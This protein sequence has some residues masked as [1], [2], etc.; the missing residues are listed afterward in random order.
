MIL[1]IEKHPSKILST[2]TE[3][4][5]LA[6]IKGYEIQTLIEDMMDTCLNSEGVGLA[7][8]QVG[9]GKSLFILK[10]KNSNFMVFINPKIIKKADPQHCK[11]EG[12]LSLP[13]RRFNVKRHKKVVLAFFNENG[14]EEEV[15]TTKSK[16]MAQAI[17]HEMD[18]LKG[19]T[20]LDIG[21]EV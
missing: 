6:E 13:G 11:N 19:L 15:F 20:L 5:T 2:P 18:H 12:C 7:A 10:N 17:L 8:N 9:V 14:E 3:P 1:E 16:R 21:K 4:L